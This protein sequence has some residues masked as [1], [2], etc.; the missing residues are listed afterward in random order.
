MAE[1]N[2]VADILPLTPFQEGVLFHALYDQDGPDVYNVQYRLDLAG[3]LDAAAMR[4]AADALV[5]RHAALRAAFRQRGNGQS[6]QLIIE[7]VAAA[8]RE[9]DLRELPGERRDAEV[10]RLTA[11]ELDRRFDLS[12][13]ESLRFTLIHRG[14]GRSRLL[15]TNH[16]I[17]LD[18][19][20]MPILLQELFHLYEKRGDDGELPAPVPHRDHLAWAVRQDAGKAREA[21]RQTL[22]GL[23]EPT[24]V[25]PVDPSLPPVMPGKHKV[26]LP[27]ELMAAMSRAA[28]GHGLTLNTVIQGA[29]GL[30][31][32]RLTGRDDVCFGAT[33]SGRAP[34]VA[35]AEGMVGSFI[36]VVPVRV[37]PNA[38]R[39]VAEMLAEIQDQQAEMMP[40]QHLGMAE[41]QRMAGLGQLF[42]TVVV[43]ENYPL[44]VS[45][46]D[47]PAEGLSL[48]G[49][50]VHDAAHFPLRLVVLPVPDP[51]LHIDYRPDLV[52]A[53]EAEAVADRL[54]RLLDQIAGAPE[55]EVG[56]LSILA[57]GERARLLTGLNGTRRPEAFANLLERVREMA[58][59][60]WEEPAVIAD[61]AR[62]TYG[63]LCGRAGALS[64]RLRSLGARPGGMCAIY[65]SRGAR[66][67]AGVLGVLGADNAFLPLDTRAPVA[68]NAAML[69]AS[70]AEFLLAGPE[71]AGTAA[72]I[73]AAA[74][75]SCR[76]VAL[77]GSATPDGGFEPPEVRPDQPAYML[78][79]SGSTGL[80]KG[81]LVH[82]GGMVNHL[83]AKNEDLE[84]GDSDIV[85]QNAPLTFDVSVWQMLTASTVGG[86][87][88]VVGDDVALDPVALFRRSERERV[89]VLEVVPSLLRAALDAWDDGAPLPD[90]GALRRLLVTGES[91]SADL[92]R[93]WF[94]RFP[95]VP[96][97]NAYGPTECSDDV[98][99]GF[100]TSAA[101][102]PDVVA[103]IG[104]PVRNLE[105]YVLDRTLQPVPAGVPG[106]LYVGG[107]GVG[108]G[109]LGRPA[110]TAVS[111]VADPFSG[112]AGDRLYRTGDLVRALP[113]GQL[114]FLGR[115]DHQVKIRGQ[116][117]ELGEIEAALRTTPGVKDA[118]VMLRADVAGHE[119]LV[120]YLAG[121]AGQEDARET[122][123]AQLPP[124][125]VPA[126]FVLLK[127]LPV[128]ANGK[129]DRAALPTPDTPTSTGRPPRTP[130]ETTLAELFTEILGIPHITIDDDFFH[131]GGHSLLATRLASRIRTTLGTDLPTRAIFEHPTITT[132]ATRLHPDP[133]TDTETD[134]ETGTGTTGTQRPALTPQPRPPT[135]PLSH[136]QRRLWLLAELE[137]PTPTYNLPTALRFH[138]P[139]DTNALRAA[140]RD[141][142]ERHESL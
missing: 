57:P 98:T 6:V 67:I 37:R 5:R 68:R 39:P 87:V 70:G 112:R 11:E 89:T 122:A 83:A 130:T 51:Q 139:I 136:A 106:E 69:R 30:L 25:V 140:L 41:I 27:P 79:T 29:W 40:H 9:E 28:Q 117:V 48:V 108:L 7:G 64:R 125:M 63:E 20:S 84:L 21:W 116:R 45:T 1:R 111:F 17:L 47:A 32:A 31:L 34:E 62:V 119:R 91:L 3:D 99:H 92:C 137:G 118:V 56:R 123:E 14:D 16:H 97:V 94:R 24:I 49:A 134:T 103:P 50:D 120:A 76:I 104:R 80:P 77:D 95:G 38:A 19:W 71:H 133:E 44:D 60:H 132:L 4:A 61:D 121:S 33:V 73:A 82:H 54:I 142:L 113:D 141:V 10:A 52:T 93:R 131:L 46:F 15:L 126:V 105:L 127:T 88:V 90:L 107:Q 23:A 81:A 42:D 138:G 102:V 110:A 128:S 72:E 65:A 18:G 36:N 114:E 12:R 2:R 96:V 13:P 124:H 22:A 75:I 100:I 74:Q 58:A 135:P 109:Y 55:R 66:V 129:I 35:G 85:L 26:V 59:T 53:D 43:V 8:W 115:M 101:D 86:C 78:Y